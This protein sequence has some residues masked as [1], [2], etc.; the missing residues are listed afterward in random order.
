MYIGALFKNPALYDDY[1][2]DHKHFQRE[3]DWQF[4]YGIF[5][6]MV[7]KNKY[8][9]IDNFTT[10]TFVREKLSEKHSMRYEKMGGFEAINS[11]IGIVEEDNIQQHYDDVLKYSALFEMIKVGFDV[12]S[13]W[14]DISGF[15]Y[16]SLSLYFDKIN[17]RVFP[18]HVANEDKVTDILSGL[19]DM[20][21]D[22][23]KGIH[24]GLPVA[25][26]ALNSLIHGQILG[27]ISL[28]A[29]QSGVGKTFLAITLVLPKVIEN[30]EKLL[31]MCNEED[32][33][34]WQQQII[35]WAINN[36]IVKQ[37]EFRGMEFNKSRFYEGN[38]TKEEKILLA[39][40]ID[41]MKGKIGEGLISFVNFS[42]FSMNKAI[43][44]IRKTSEE[45]G[46]RYF[47]LDTF[48]L[49]NDASS[50]VEDIA[51]LQLQQNIVKLFNVIK[52]TVNNVH[53]WMTYQL[54][55]T[56]RKYLDQS[57]LGMSKNVADVVSTLLL[58]RNVTQKEKD[59]G[60]LK[61]RN[62]ENSFDKVVL[63]PQEDY[64][65][66]FIEKNRSGSSSEQ[67]VLATDKGRN[68]IRDVGYTRIAEDF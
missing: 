16:R 3:G 6:S 8:V 17:A 29:A 22:A 49:D 15:N 65:V 20:V 66:I 64:M 46:I 36:H 67:V 59:S 61:I 42:T 58:V 35:T 4:F 5:I 39:K 60:A 51:W 10:D 27:N 43:S 48:K 12:E 1:Q 9:K 44:A 38:F 28:L 34:K 63:D 24:A 14:K 30:K 62:P 54:N 19:E 13:N 11:A 52:S 40:G 25:S 2:I 32:Q 23:N 47:I 41:W 7:K 56:T 68:V 45:D 53:V 18:E 31:I 33:G 21:K 57:S 55:K 37:P 50:K 26:E